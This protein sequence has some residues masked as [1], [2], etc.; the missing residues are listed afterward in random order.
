MTTFGL[1]HGAWHG[2]WC[3]ELLEH[4]LTARGHR[5]ASM[6]LPITD[7]HAGSA[8]YA[9][10]VG[11]ALP[12]GDDDIVLVGHSL[13]GVT[14]PIVALARPVRRTVY[15]CG[16]M[17]DP[18]RSLKEC[19]EDG[20]DADMTPPGI[21]GLDYADDGASTWTSFA[22]ARRLMYDDVAETAARRAFERLRP[23][24]TLWFET[25]PNDRW[26]D[27]PSTYILCAEDRI[28][29]PT[30][31]RRTVPPR[32][33]VDPIELPGSHSP[34]LSRPADLADLLVDTL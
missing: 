34:M 7:P 33:G 32:L 25:A 29:D 16:V 12:A 11:Q 20:T 28:V 5:A 13:A 24:Y 1:V 14:L 18:G 2:A 6:D 26:P 8:A 31:A 10:V 3:W 15:L 19:S 27:V 22:D 21:T 4:E 17:R 9:Q 30:W 23:Q